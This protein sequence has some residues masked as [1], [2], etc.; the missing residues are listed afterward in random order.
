MQYILVEKQ[1]HQP[2]GKFLNS[3]PNNFLT[4]EHTCCMCSDMVRV[5]VTSTSSKH[6]LEH[7]HLNA[8][9]KWAAFSGFNNDFDLFKD[10]YK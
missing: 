7:C 10:R 2:I 9:L 6:V 5:S 8:M 3:I 1:M 4:F